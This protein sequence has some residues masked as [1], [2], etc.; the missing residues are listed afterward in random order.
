MR[1]PPVLLMGALTIVFT[2]CTRVG[3]ARPVP[4]QPAQRME[5][6]R[7]GPTGPSFQA[8]EG[9]LGLGDQEFLVRLR[10]E[11]VEG[12]EVQAVLRIPALGLEASGDGTATANRLALSL[13][14]NDGCEGVLTIEALLSNDG[15][16]G[17]GTLDVVDCTGR[18]SGALALARLPEGA[19]GVLPLP[20]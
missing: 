7:S 18:E 20:R 11:R 19:P 1:T 3:S 14:Y 5:T 13:R 8:F 4:V 10:L 2:A 15:L 12:A 16:S 6:S 17:D 9:H